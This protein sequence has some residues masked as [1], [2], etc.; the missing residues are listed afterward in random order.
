MSL[1]LG[2]KGAA[3]PS[4]TASRLK[5]ISKRTSQ[6]KTFLDIGPDIC[7][8]VAVTDKSH[9]SK[10]NREVEIAHRIA[11]VI[12]H[13]ENSRQRGR[14]F[15]NHLYRLRARIEQAIGKLKHFKR[16]ATRCEKTDTSYSAIVSLACA[17][18]II[19]SVNTA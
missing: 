9:D 5:S 3:A 10:D 14:F 8:R 4:A 12:P 11:P 17:I 2:Q 7:P 16:V 15:H 13:R 6:F 18:I 1:P 19:K